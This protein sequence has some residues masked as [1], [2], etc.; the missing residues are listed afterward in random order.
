MSFLSAPGHW[1]M[2]LSD[3]V[4]AEAEAISGFQLILMNLT[5]DIFGSVKSAVL[6]FAH[7]PRL[8]FSHFLI[9]AEYRPGSINLLV[10]L[11]RLFDL[12]PLLLSL[13]S[14]PDA[15]SEQLYFVH[16]CQSAGLFS[17]E[18]AREAIG[19]LSEN[20]LANTLFRGSQ[21]VPLCAEPFEASLREDDVAA[22]S[23]I[24]AELALAPD[25][26]IQP[27]VLFG[28][29]FLRN[30]PTLLHY[31]AFFGA[32]DCF[33]FLLENGAS[34][35]LRDEAGRTLA[36]FA[37]AGGN[38]EVLAICRSRRC[39]FSGSERVAV[40]FHRNAAFDHYGDIMHQ[41]TVSNN[42]ALIVHCLKR[43]DA[44]N[45][46]DNSGKAPLHVAV[47]FDSIQAVW[48]LCQHPLVNVNLATANDSRS[49]ALHIAAE[50]GH[51]ECVRVLLRHSLINQRISN[52]AG[53][54]PFHV[55]VQRGNRDIIHAMLEQGSITISSRTD[56]G[57]TALH[58]AASAGNID[59]M[60]FLIGLGAD[61]DAKTLTQETVLHC[62]ARA[63]KERAVEMLVS[64]VEDVNPKDADG[65]TPLHYATQRNYTATVEVLLG[66]PRIS[67]NCKDQSGWTAVHIAVKNGNMD[68]VRMLLAMPDADINQPDNGGW[69]LLHLAAKSGSVKLVDLLLSVEGVAI[70]AQDAAGW[71]A[72]HNAAKY[73]FH[74]V[75]ERLL[76]EPE[77]DVNI[78]TAIGWTPL[79]LACL[80]HDPKTEQL[81][82]DAPDIIIDLKDNIGRT[83][84]DLA[85]IPMFG[86]ED[87]HGVADLAEYFEGLWA[88]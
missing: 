62:A 27:S 88:D 73:Q 79:H 48:L 66:D 24:F 58:W 76:E 20:T 85:K 50:R 55:A 4:L 72:L 81:L 64:D 44:P 34:T 86:G 2:S 69:T 29:H 32:A 28:C 70:N 6:S 68:L 75:I 13:L 59:L 80:N 38:S 39:N 87:Y 15:N 53:Q 3:A 67:V 22:F 1:W 82:T 56:Y 78:Q 8:L 83:P 63:G 23:T 12:K 9:A 5:R 49:T 18:E 35:D 54:L 52:K 40:R 46:F 77:I 19:G 7:P 43:G 74:Q 61:L 47:E 14:S 33:R 60:N 25:T 41:C 26:R 36:Q 21:Q 31:A 65:W 57:T 37:A 30:R 16:R 51:L 42:V 45:T 17:D 10:D 11:C 71:T 84:A